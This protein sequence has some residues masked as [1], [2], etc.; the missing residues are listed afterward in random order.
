MILG[1]L[2]KL[3]IPSLV[4]N[5][6][7]IERVC[8][9]KLLGVYISN[10]LSWNLHVDYICAIA[11]ARLHRNFHLF[12]VFAK[13]VQKVFRCS[14]KQSTKL[15]LDNGGNILGVSALSILLLNF[16]YLDAN[17]PDGQAVP[18][19]MKCL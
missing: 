1:P 14:H 12:L 16:S 15:A 8:G 5:Y 6:N 11:N 10:D 7:S 9:F 19:L 13:L 18:Q 17:L 2:S 4:I 3:G